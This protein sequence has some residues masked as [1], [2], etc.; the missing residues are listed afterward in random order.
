MAAELLFGRYR[1]LESAGSGGSA[2]VWRAN[3]TTTGEDVAVKRLHPIVFAEPDARRRLEREFHALQALDEPHVVRVRDLHVADN[4]AAIVLDYVDGPSLARRLAEGPPFAPAEAVAIASDVAAALA[5]AHAAGIVHRDVT[6]GNI[7]LAPDGTA[8]LT[9]FGIA[10]AS[11]DVTA[12]TGPGLVMGTMRYLA[13]EQ[14]RGA[15]A[16]PASDLHA[17]AAVTYQMLAG[18]PAYEA[19]TP[20][21]L[22]EAQAAGAAP[23][24]GVPTELDAA[25]RAGLAID[26]AER[27]ADVATFARSLETA[28]AS[29]A[30]A[31]IALDLDGR[32]QPI[33]VAAAGAAATAAGAAVLAASA[34][35][36]A[37]AA[38]STA[39]DA[40]APAL[41]A[42]S[43]PALAARSTGRVNTTES[44]AEAGPQRPES[45]ES[46][47]SVAPGEQDEPVPAQPGRIHSPDE[48]RARDRRRGAPLPAPL[49]A[50]LGLVLVA[51]VAMAA[52]EGPLPSDAPAAGAQ[53]S[54]TLV[55]TPVPT[56]VPPEEDEEPDEGGGNGN[57]NGKGNG[58][59]KGKGPGKPGD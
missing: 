9:D 23:I 35:S 27:P 59:D 32:T 44:T 12:V 6:P 46:G 20:V 53:A 16:T 13:P 48:N 26:P 5:A 38:P 58:E 36:S 45:A 37:P 29:A 21:G 39:P 55:P 15:P 40:S 22:A 51:A 49:L 18:R 42:A 17:L 10:H 4:D 30:T 56:E 7:L 1:L 28:L 57:G 31:P 43:A 8:R 25:V 14:L 19:T 33:A 41:A 24:G 54:P 47:A 34:S 11:T 52:G 3:D 2:E 50:L